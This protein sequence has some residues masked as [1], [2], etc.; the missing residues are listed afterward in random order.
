MTEARIDF[1]DGAAYER[2]MGRWSR[3]VAPRFLR[4]MA[5]PRQA[6]WLDVGCGT[7]V[8][9]EVLADQ[10]D[11]ACVVGVDASEAQ[12]EQAARSA[13]AARVQFQRADA[14]QLP[15]APDSFDAAASALVLNF[16]AD[17]ALALQEMRRVTRAG[18]IVGVYVWDFGNE[19]SPSGPLRRAMRALGMPAPDIPGTAQSSLERL[20]AL[21]RR[22]GL[23]SIA[24]TSVE[25][26]LAY[27]DFDDFWI[28]QT[29]G[30]APAT[31]TINA[32]SAGERRRLQRAVQEAL[33]SGPNGRIEYAARANA[34]R[35]LVPR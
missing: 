22:A 32:M 4:W 13:A 28:A 26:T 19:L 11:P 25:V 5:P 31:K 34:I 6:R 10:C 17:P 18:G 9:A 27:A 16:I 21:F 3:A 15:F 33:S 23:E 7:G 1:S 2:S 24:T 30:Y 8:L 20:E 12:I 35:A 14:A 29:P